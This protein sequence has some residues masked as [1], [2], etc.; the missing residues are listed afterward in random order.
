M[1]E[2]SICLGQL[3]NAIVV[4]PETMEHGLLHDSKLCAVPLNNPG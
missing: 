2:L 3:G 4:V 1:G